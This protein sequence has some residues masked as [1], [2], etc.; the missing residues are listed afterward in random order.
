MGKLKGL[1]FLVLMLLSIILVACNSDD[2][3]NSEVNTDANTSGEQTEAVTGGDLVLATLSDAANLDPHLSTDVPSASVLSNIT[4]GLV[5][6]NQNDEI[7]GSLAESWEAIDDVTWEFKLVEGVKF[8]DGEDFN[9]EV[10][11][12]NFERLL[13]PEIAAPRAFLFESIKEVEV[14]DE[15][16]VRIH[17]HYPFA[18]LINHLNHPVGVMISPAQIDADYESMAAGNSPGQLVN[19]EGPV[20]TGFMKFDYWTAGAEIKLVNN[21]EYWGQKAFVDSVTIKV[22]PESATRVAELE[23]GNAHIIEP[24]QPNEVALVES[25]PNSVDVAPGSSLSYVGFNVEKEPFNDVRVRQ[26]ISML[27]DQQM[28]IDGIYDGFGEAAIGPL[29]PNVFGYDSTLQPLTYNLEKAQQLL[30]EAGFADGF[31]TTIWTNDNPQRQN[32]AIMLQ[33]ELRKVNID[34]A[35]EVVEWGAYLA[36]TGA[37]EHDMFILGLSN[38][39][40]DADY[41]LTQLFHSKNKGDPGNRTFYENA[42]I[43]SLLDQ[44]RE[45]ID[46]TKRLALYKE[47]QER[48]IEEA[49]MVYVHHQAYL[50][51]VSEQI[52]GYWINDSGHHKLQNVKFVK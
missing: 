11:K 36:K 50:S 28:I 20:G 9:A 30:T 3:E 44:A 5:K 26:A 7:V 32:I 40:G 25:S 23:T 41:F 21:T 17:T 19:M 27:V 42:E 6:K 43:D 48:L 4:E 15:Y 38:P 37:G 49:P 16:V 13:D 45:E 31:K 10:V 51:G 24:I 22:I 2:V 1:L 12:K 47:L 33:E 14:V 34:A 8:H 18:P 29:A 35:I 46:T 39:V 52:E